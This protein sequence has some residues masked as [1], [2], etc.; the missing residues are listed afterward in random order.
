MERFAQHRHNHKC[1]SQSHCRPPRRPHHEH[2]RGSQNCLKIGQFRPRPPPPGRTIQG[3]ALAGATQ[4][5]SVE[6]GEAGGGMMRIALVCTLLTVAMP[7]YAIDGNTLYDSCLGSKGMALGYVSGVIDEASSVSGWSLIKQ[8]E[9]FQKHEPY[10]PAYAEA[11]VFS[12]GGAC[13]PDRY[14][15]GQATDV[16]CKY[17]A[18][19]PE[20]RQEPAS[21]LVK[22][23]F[24]HAWPCQH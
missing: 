18:A 12:Q 6:A 10:N 19:T 23:A 17:L 21:D 8:A 16:V 5:G 9:A 7:A 22:A 11:W 1:T 13:L 14:T 24:K 4:A 20:T 3:M 2:Q 15:L